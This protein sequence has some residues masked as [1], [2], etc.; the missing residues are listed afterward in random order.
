MSN[1]SEPDCKGLENQIKG[2]EASQARLQKNLQHAAGEEKQTLVQEIRE[3][4][5]EIREKQRDFNAKRCHTVTMKWTVAGV[6]RE[7]LVFPPVTEGKHPLIFAW[8]AHGGTMGG[9]A[10]QMHFQT[11]WHEAIVV[12]PQGLKTETGGDDAGDH[13]GWQKELDPPNRDLAFFDAMLATLR[14]KYS[15]DGRRI[16]TAGYSNGTGFSYLLWVERGQT[17]AAIGAVSGVMMKSEREKPAHPRALIS[18]A[19]T[20]SGTRP[21]AVQR[22]IKRAR[23]I[24]N[25]PGPRQ[26]C[27]IPNGAPVH[28]TCFLYQSTSHTPVKE[29]THPGGHVPY[30]PWAP[31]EIVEF[32]KHHERP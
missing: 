10:E 4:E 30:P 13:P 1:Q 28:T 14:Q 7:A 27:A 25:A 17:L 18:I 8:H 2:L 26:S 16:Y 6:S 31:D 11:G 20:G 24:N 9:A 29:I 3:L 19:G 5:S 12:Y 15:I 32:F 22:T 23:E 21:D